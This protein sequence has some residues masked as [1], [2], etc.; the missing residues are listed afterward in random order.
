MLSL[1][2]ISYAFEG[3][4]SNLLIVAIF[5][6]VVIY[7]YFFS[8]STEKIIIANFEER[9][10]KE[11]F[12]SLNKNLEQKVSEQT[13]EIKGAYDIEKKAKENLQD[14]DVQKNEFMMITQHHL[15]TPLTS[16]M[17]YV[18]LLEDGAY[19]KVPPKIEKVVERFGISSGKLL[20]V[21]NEFLDLSQFEMG[22]KVIKIER[23][24]DVKAII[25][26]TMNEL[27]PDAKKKGLTLKFEEPKEDIPKIQV[28]PE[29]CRW[30]LLM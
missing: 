1:I 27:S 16:M 29:S 7:G 15:R 22:E 25:K 8:R 20:R 3:K 21:V 24:V 28:N 9:K 2:S 23:N 10:A 18:S 19:G 17:G 30:C 5:T 26:S 6:L 13:K 14:L 11:S 4:I 12:E